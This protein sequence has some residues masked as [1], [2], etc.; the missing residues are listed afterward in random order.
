MSEQ[1]DAFEEATA[2][3]LRRRGFAGNEFDSALRSA[4]DQVKNPPRVRARSVEYDDI[5]KGMPRKTDEAD[6]G[7]KMGHE[8]KPE[9]KNWTSIPL[10]E[11]DKAIYH[12]LHFHGSDNKFG[13]HTHLR[14]GELM[15]G[16]TH[17]P[18]NRLGAHHHRVLD[19]TVQGVMIDG[20]H[21]HETGQNLPCGPHTHT[22]ENFG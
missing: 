11:A 10:T 2:R 1:H 3:G 12:G 7:D 17:G 5:N 18:Q 21:V 9:V 19:D 6:P 20:F 4:S 15:G 14:G 13:L 22:P 16:H 8:V